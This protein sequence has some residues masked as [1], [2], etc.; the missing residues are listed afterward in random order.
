MTTTRNHANPLWTSLRIH[1]GPALVGGMFLVLADLMANDRTAQI[2]KLGSVLTRH[3]L[4]SS[5][6][7]PAILGAVVTLV[8]GC[9]LCWVYRPASPS[10]SLTKGASVF[11]LLAALVP[12]DKIPGTPMGDGSGKTAAPASRSASP[13]E[14]QRPFLEMLAN[15]TIANARGQ[16][17]IPVDAVGKAKIF[18]APGPEV[19]KDA[20]AE[21]VRLDGIALWLF[22]DKGAPIAHE[23]ITAPQFIVSKPAGKYSLELDIPGYRL[24]R[25][26]LSLEKTPKVYDLYLGEPTGIPLSFQRLIGPDHKSLVLNDKESFKFQGT[27]LYKTGNFGAAIALYDM[28]LKLAPKDTELLNFKGY[29]LYKLSRFN[30]AAATLRDAVNADPSYYLAR[31]NSAKA[32]CRL[33]RPE[34]ARTAILGEPVLGK[35]YLAVIIADGEFVADCKSIAAEV[36]H[37][38]QSD[39]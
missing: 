35:K 24:L 38:L 21:R 19:P 25:V 30:E 29:A 9:L 32:A 36:K 27:E 39:L 23:R 17:A 33:N 12:A 3:F 15:W 5:G 16:S 4:P 22:D 26:P 20:F 11:A 8:L 10:D 28:A 31:L 7:A 1:Y 34:D 2:V 13:S 18:I 14:V 6:M 37:R